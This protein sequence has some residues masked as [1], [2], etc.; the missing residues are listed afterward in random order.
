MSELLF[1][2]LSRAVAT[3]PAGPAMAGPVFVSV[4][5]AHAQYA[6]LLLLVQ[7]RLSY[8]LITGAR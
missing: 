6:Y 8:E 2:L 7:L 4:G 1:T 3:S 5:F